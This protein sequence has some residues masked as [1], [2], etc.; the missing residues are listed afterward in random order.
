[1]KI[2][3]GLQWKARVLEGGELERVRAERARWQSLPRIHVPPEA[4]YAAPQIVSN[5]I[6]VIG[7][8]R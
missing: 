4:I 6:H 2:D 3:L 8:D 1:M 5:W 7:L